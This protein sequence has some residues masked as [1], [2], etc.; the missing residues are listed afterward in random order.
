MIAIAA[1]GGHG[2]APVT[3]PAPVAKSAPAAALLVGPTT[4]SA[5]VVLTKIRTEYIGRMKT[6]YR[7]LLKQHA[8]ARGR[9]LITFTVDPRGRASRGEAHG[10]ADKVDACIA[11]QIASWQ[12]PAPRDP[13]GAPTE[14]SFAV[15][16]ELTAID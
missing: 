3:R 11:A 1:C 13:A 2:P 6:C 10:F 16:L 15:P 14:A 7:V 12:F 5:D 9:V 8:S 4:L